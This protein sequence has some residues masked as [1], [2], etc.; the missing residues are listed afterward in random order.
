MSNIIFLD[1]ATPRYNRY[2]FL[3]PGSFISGF[4]AGAFLVSRSSVN[5]APLICCA[6]QV[7]ASAFGLFLQIALTFSLTAL[8]CLSRRKWLILLQCFVHSLSFGILAAGAFHAYVS[9]HWLICAI[10]LF[11]KTITLA[12]AFWF[13]FRFLTIHPDTIHRDFL[14]ALMVSSAAAVFDII[15]VSSIFV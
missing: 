11:T 12:C 8:I 15:F 4:L 6:T 10:V 5:Y 14:V 9:A 13:W 7:P 3:L 1:R 2:A